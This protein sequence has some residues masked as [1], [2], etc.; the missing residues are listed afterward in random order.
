MSDAESK[1][2]IQAIRL[3]LAEVSNEL[4]RF[5]HDVQNPLSILTGNVE[6]I[7][8][9]TA[10]GGLDSGVQESLDDIQ[11][12]A[13]KLSS[14][15]GRLQAIRERVLELSASNEPGKS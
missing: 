1:D 13:H 14:I 7:N 8:A 4:S 12:A 2:A 9:L 10:G 15:V 5:S 6:L 3:S 11:A